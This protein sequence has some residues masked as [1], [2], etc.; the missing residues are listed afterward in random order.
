MA[1]IYFDTTPLIYFLDDE[2]PFSDNVV[3]FNSP[4]DKHSL[5]LRYIP[6]N[7]NDYTNSRFASFF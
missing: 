5:A 3:S 4:G 6:N 2:N 1:K 7:M